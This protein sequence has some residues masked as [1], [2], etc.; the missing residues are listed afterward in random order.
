MDDN[1]MLDRVGKATYEEHGWLLDLAESP[2]ISQ[3][4]RIAAGDKAAQ[5]LMEH[6]YLMDLYFQANNK[7]MPPE[8]QQTMRLAAENVVARNTDAELARR[9]PE[10]LL[11]VFKNRN[12]S[13]ST[14]SGFKKTAQKISIR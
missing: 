1:G 9:S 5:Q 13:P 3:V 12:V 4:V 14:L 8:V 11:L 6:R 7:K 10:K 2:L